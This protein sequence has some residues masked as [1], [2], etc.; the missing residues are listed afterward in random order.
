MPQLFTLGDYTWYWF[1]IHCS[2][3]RLKQW[4]CSLRVSSV[5]FWSELGT[6]ESLLG[7]V[8]Y[9]IHSAKRAHSVPPYISLRLT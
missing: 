6:K 7:A 9:P 2:F 4:D 1:R 3:I 8:C 5:S